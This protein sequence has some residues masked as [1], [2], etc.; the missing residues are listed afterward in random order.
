M[1]K[2]LIRKH[3]CFGLHIQNLMWKK[4]K[5]LTTL[6]LVIGVITFINFE[7]DSDSL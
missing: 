1:L 2:A 6:G 5:T 7:T 3:A 4:K